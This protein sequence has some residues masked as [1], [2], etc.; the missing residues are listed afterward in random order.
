[1]TKGTVALLA[2]ALVACEQPAPAPTDASAEPASSAAPSL[3]TSG[4]GAP[5]A[6]A[7]AP[8]TPE[9]LEAAALATQTAFVKAVIA[10]RDASAEGSDE[11]KLFQ[12]VDAKTHNAEDDPNE[13]LGRPGQY[14]AKMTWTTNGEDATIEVFAN[15]E[16]AA[17]RAKY[18]ETVGKSAPM[19]LQYVYVHPKRHAVLR[20]PKQLTP[21]K[22]KA[23]ESVL[24]AL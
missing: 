15:G 13:L 17:T 6:T 18:L 12:M 16:D 21:S 20:V 3:A 5:S 22:A 4:S 2:L 23:W 10:K 8:L 1:M 14:I 19:F 11:R 9:Q 24:L 7:T